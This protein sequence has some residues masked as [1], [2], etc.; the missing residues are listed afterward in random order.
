VAIE[1]PLPD[2]LVAALARARGGGRG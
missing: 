2:D 1:S